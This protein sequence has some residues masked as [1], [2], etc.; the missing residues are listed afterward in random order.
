MS[1]SL[2]WRGPSGAWVEILRVWAS[3]AYAGVRGPTGHINI[4][5]LIVWHG[6]L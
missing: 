3:E 1:P 6:L 2:E 5:I 4:R